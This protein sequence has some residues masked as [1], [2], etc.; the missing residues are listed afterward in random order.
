APPA[1]GWLRLMPAAGF[2][3]LLALGQMLLVPAAKGLSAAVGF[4]CQRGRYSPPPHPPKVGC[5]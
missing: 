2:V 4:L 5:G 3:T 1:E